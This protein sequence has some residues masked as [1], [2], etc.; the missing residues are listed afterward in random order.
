MTILAIC[1]TVGKWESLKEEGQENGKMG[2]FESEEV[3]KW[4]SGKVENWK[5]RNWKQSSQ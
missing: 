1:G 3:G 4:G 2:K 5:I